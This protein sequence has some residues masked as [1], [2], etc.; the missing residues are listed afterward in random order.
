MSAR[1]LTW[2]Q[3]HLLIISHSPS[4]IEQGDERLSVI[5]SASLCLSLLVE[6][7]QLGHSVKRVS[8]MA[9]DI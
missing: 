7:L 2:Q 4:R 1:E 6:V 3:V 9:I 5:S 8:S